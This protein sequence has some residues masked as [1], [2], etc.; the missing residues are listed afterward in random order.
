MLLNIT[1][2]FELR[3]QSGCQTTDQPKCDQK[4]SISTGGLERRIQGHPQMG[5]PRKNQNRYKIAARVAAT[6]GL[7]P[8][9]L[10]VGH[11]RFS[12]KAICFLAGEPPYRLSRY[13]IY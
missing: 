6:G 13:S 4:E 8:D 1:D 11:L 3:I 5:F 10:I 7:Y 9:P 2:E 12:H